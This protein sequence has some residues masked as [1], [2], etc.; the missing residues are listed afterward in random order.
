MLASLATGAVGLAA[1]GCSSVG[2]PGRTA[3]PAAPSPDVQV[4][5]EA[6]AAI[7][8]T[9]DLVRRTAGRYAG[10]RPSLAPLLAMHSAHLDALGK[11]VTVTPSARPVPLPVPLPVPRRRA[12]VSADVVKA[13]REL[14]D[15]LTRLA[16]V[17]QSGAFAR[18]LA[19][20]V[21]SVGQ[22]TVGLAG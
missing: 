5:V 10:L 4:A 18:L 9:R 2:L 14:G 21:A 7:T 12:A 17:A 11:A 19:S 1:A 20:M 8:A 13:E 15:T 6:V 3:R 22:H 16:L